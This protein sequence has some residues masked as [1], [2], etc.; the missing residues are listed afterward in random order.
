MK[1]KMA[2]D[3]VLKRFSRQIRKEDASSRAR[4]G[5]REVNCRKPVHPARSSVWSEVSSASGLKSLSWLHPARLSD[6]S[7]VSFSQAQVAELG[8]V[9][10]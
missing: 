7:E 6:W 2:A 3:Q 9:G 1:L 10:A 8:A 4:S 5:S